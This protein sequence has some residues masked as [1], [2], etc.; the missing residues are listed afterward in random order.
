[1]GYDAFVFDFFGVVC[2]EVAPLW[3]RKYLS[4]KK[5]VEVKSR[6]VGPADRGEVSQ[7]ELFMKLGA[8]AGMPAEQVEEEWRTY[9]LID[10]DVV[11]IV[12]SL[13]KDHKVALLTNATSGFLRDILIGNNLSGLFDPVVV[14]SEE[15]VAKPDPLIYQKVLEQLSFP[16]GKVLMID[17][18]PANIR[19]A[20]EAG[21][22]GV[23]FEC[24]DRLREV[25]SG[26][27]FLSGR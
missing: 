16:P 7:E 27:S 23:V 2:S 19:G 15:R 26:W 6:L 21:M 3:F 20:I 5:A 22:G 18:N 14:S 10:K 17:D 24:A 8:F 11:G 12:K 25:L 13:R 9:V 4:E 1:M